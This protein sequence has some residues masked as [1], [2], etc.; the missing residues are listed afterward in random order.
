MQTINIKHL[1]Y[2]KMQYFTKLHIY[3]P[4]AS[5]TL[6]CNSCEVETHTT[7][8]SLSCKT[9]MLKTSAGNVEHCCLKAIYIF[10]QKHQS[11]QLVLKLKH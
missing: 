7:N 4:I 3:L 11:S 1:C 6:A 5:S 10:T 9:T 2:L 8:T